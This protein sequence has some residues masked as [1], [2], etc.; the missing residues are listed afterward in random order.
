MTRTE[1]RRVGNGDSPLGVGAGSP[2]CHPGPCE[3]ASH[4][5]RPRDRRGRPPRRRRAARRPRGR[6]VERGPRPRRP[7]RADEPA[8]R[9]ARRSSPADPLYVICRS[10]N[11]SARVVAFLS[12]QGVSAV[13]VEGGMQ[14]WAAAGRP[15]VAEHAA[16]RRA[17]SRTARCAR[18][19]PARAAAVRPRRTGPARTAGATSRRSPGSPSR[20]HRPPRRRPRARPATPDRRA[21]GSS[22]AGASRRCPG[23][24]PARSQPH[25]RAQVAPRRVEGLGP[26]PQAQ[27]DVLHD[28]PA[29]AG[30]RRTTS[31]V[32]WT[33]AACW[34][35]TRA[36]Q[37]RIAEIRR[38]G[39][40]SGHAPS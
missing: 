18:W 16:P 28:V 12:Q 10:G 8:H 17:S 4:V 31:A 27:E 34:A 26:P 19:S 40:F 35:N 20:P 30:S 6:R 3:D 39:T 14:S 23:S 37:C 7:A 13:N 9:Q 25:E 33:A 32:P 11:R 5:R 15:M 38:R 29:R 36:K 2:G 21:T 24:R 22:R 1:T